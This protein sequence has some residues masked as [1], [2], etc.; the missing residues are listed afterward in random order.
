[1]KKGN[2]LYSILFMKCPR[3]HKGEVFKSK[4][5]YNLKRM[6]EMHEKCANCGLRYEIEPGFF[7]GAMYVSYGFGVA[8]FVA[9]YLIMEIIYDP[10]VWEIVIALGTVVLLGS[11]FIFRLA[12]MTYLNLFVKY[13]PSKTG[14][15]SK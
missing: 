6:F 11:P 10:S 3:C 4:N 14:N 2:K 12:R 7:Y 9:T 15:T 1:M 13:D 5:P 8:F